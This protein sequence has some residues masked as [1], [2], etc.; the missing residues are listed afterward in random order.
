MLKYKL[1]RE[2]TRLTADSN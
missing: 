1:A 2:L